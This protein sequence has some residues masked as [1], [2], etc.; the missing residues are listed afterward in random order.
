MRLRATAGRALGRVLAR[1]RARRDGEPRWRRSHLGRAHRGDDRSCCVGTS[2]R[3]TTRR[4]ARTAAGSSPPG[5]RRRALWDATS[6]ARSSTSLRGAR[7]AAPRGRVRRRQHADRHARARRRCELPLRYLRR[8]SALGSPAAQLDAT[9]RKLSTAERALPRRLADRPA[10]CSSS[11]AFAVSALNPASRK[12]LTAPAA[13]RRSGGGPC[14]G[15]GSASTPGRL[16]PTF[17]RSGCT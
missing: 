2:A 10:R 4:S 17:R 13:R 9:G 16:R 14:V 3:R 11:F 7:T 1:R 5:R 12:S 15:R 6:G 8:A